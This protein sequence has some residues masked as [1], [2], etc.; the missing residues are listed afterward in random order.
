M[1]G[2]SLTKNYIVEA[3]DPITALSHGEELKRR[4]SQ[5]RERLAR[6]GLERDNCFSLLYIDIDNFRYYTIN[7]GDEVGELIVREFAGVIRKLLRKVDLPAR[8]GGD[9]FAVMLVHTNAAG[10]QTFCDRLHQDLELLA[11]FQHKIEEFLNR[12]IEVPS[13]KRLTCSVG[14][15]V[16]KPGDERDESAILDSAKSLMLEA[17]KLGKNRCL[18]EHQ[19]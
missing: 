1:N 16:C 14:I 19:I 2:E 4:I 18:A 11:N 5:E 9:E 12:G 8:V 7:H 13:D 3:I 15:T 10:A 6:F 17:K